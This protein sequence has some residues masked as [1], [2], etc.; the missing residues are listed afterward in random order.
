MVSITAVSAMLL[1]K[2]VLL[3][4]VKVDMEELSLKVTVEL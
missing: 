1:K 2:M 4:L 3:L